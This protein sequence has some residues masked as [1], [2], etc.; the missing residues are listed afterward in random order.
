MVVRR[1]ACIVERYCSGNEILNTRYLKASV[2]F[3]P[4]R[5]GWY[6]TK[7]YTERL[8]PEV[9]KKPSGLLSTI[10]VASSKTTACHGISISSFNL[11]IVEHNKF[12]AGQV[13]K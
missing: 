7:F 8:H 3:P 6:P 9:Q 2:L 13:G 11:G 4:G 5:W 12:L 10:E 1:Y